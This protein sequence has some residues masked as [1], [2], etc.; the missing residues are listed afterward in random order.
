MSDEEKLHFMK[1][2]QSFTDFLHSLNP[3]A[4]MMK[5]CL[6]IMELLNRNI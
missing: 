2:F 6:M 3:S 5:V 4:D 1:M